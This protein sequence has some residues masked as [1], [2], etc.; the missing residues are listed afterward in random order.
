MRRLSVISAFLVILVLPCMAF[1]YGIPP[2]AMPRPPRQ[3]AKCLP[4]SPTPIPFCPTFAGP[5]LPPFDPGGTGPVGG[6][7]P[8]G[9]IGSMWMKEKVDFPFRAPDPLNPQFNFEQMT[10]TMDTEQFWVG[11]VGLETEPIR[12]VIMYGEIGGTVPKDSTIRMDATGRALLPAPDNPQNLVSPWVWTAKNIHWWEMQGGA[13]FMVTPT[14]GFEVGFRTE[15][16]DYRM[17]DPRNFVQAS[18]I[19]LAA[20]L[21]PGFGIS[22]GRI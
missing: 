14:L 2:T 6:F 7:R 20:G 8:Y 18:D 9:K 4:P 10:L 12:N 3:I 1:S 13:A 15:H 11:A 16:I 17:T 5:P 22:C 21:A 19:G